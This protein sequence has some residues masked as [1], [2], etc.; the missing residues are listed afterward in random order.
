MEHPMPRHMPLLQLVKVA[1][2]GKERSRCPEPASNLKRLGNMDRVKTTPDV[3]LE[4]CE[5]EAIA[6]GM[7]NIGSEA[8]M[9]VAGR[10]ARK[11]AQK[12]RWGPTKDPGA[13]V[14]C[15][16]SAKSTPQCRSNGQ[17]PEPT[18][19]LGQQRDA[20]MVPNSEAA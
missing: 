13:K 18:I 6:S 8:G 9:Q 7:V 5:L 11:R 19:N 4:A 16:H 10:A 15:H 20:H 1:Q 12:C 2:K 3:G 17:R 14:T